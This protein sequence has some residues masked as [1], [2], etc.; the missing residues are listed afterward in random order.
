MENY[1]YWPVILNGKKLH[2]TLKYL[3]DVDVKPDKVLN[4]LKPF[5]NLLPAFYDMKREVFNHEGVDH[6]VLELFAYGLG[7]A[8]MHDALDFRA[9]D[10]PHYRPH[11]TLS[12]EIWDDLRGQSFK[13]LNFFIGM[14]R[15]SYNGADYRFNYTFNEVIPTKGLTP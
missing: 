3:G 1:I 9:D 6:Y 13:E 14:P 12:K 11:I 2:I 10:F 5:K 7:V 15:Y 4:A 8:E